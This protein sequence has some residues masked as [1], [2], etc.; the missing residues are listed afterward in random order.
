[1]KEIYSSEFKK[2]MYDAD[3]SLI[4]NEW[5]NAPMTDEDFRRDILIWVEQ[6]EKY[7]IQNMIADTRLFKFAV[8]PELQEWTN[9][10]TFPR[11]IAAG[12]K[13]FAIVESADMLAQLS[14]EQT[15]DEESTGVFAS[16][17][18]GTVEDAMKWIDK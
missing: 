14:L 9:T 8:T 5:T 11:I 6:C 3:K 1:M 15:M 2:T 17:F 7:R 10:V 18:F 12:L 13:K 16:R 4:I